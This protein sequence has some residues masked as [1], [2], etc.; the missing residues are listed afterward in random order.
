MKDPF[1]WHAGLGRKLVRLGFVLFLILYVSS[2]LVLSRIGY[3]DA[4]KY[5]MKGFLYGGGIPQKRSDL[6]FH[7]LC[8]IIYAPLNSIDCMI[9]TGREPGLHFTFAEDLEPWFRN[10]TRKKKDT[11]VEAGERGVL[12][13]RENQQPG[14]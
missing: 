1:A 3:A 8:R 7:H 13:P 6:K 9:G 14:R 2:Y 12:T 11:R 5:S 10:R 4:Q